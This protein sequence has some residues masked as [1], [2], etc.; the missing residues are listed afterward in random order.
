GLTQPDMVVCASFSYGVVTANNGCL[1][2]ELTI[3]GRATHG[4]MP[5]SGHDALR[6]A[7]RIL[8]EIY[9]QADTLDQIRSAVPGIES[10]TMIVG[11]IEGGTNTNV[12]PGRVV[13]KMD[14]RMIPEEDPAQVEAQ[15][16]AFIQAAVEGLPGIRVS[17]RRL[18]LAHPLRPLPGHE[19]MV[20][21]LQR[22]AQAI[23]GEP[24]T[25]GGTP[26]Y[27][28]ARLY[29]EH[30]IPVVMYGAGPRTLMES[31]AKQAD[32]NLAL[33]DLKAA[34]QVVAL[35]LADFLAC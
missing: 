14:R 13:L 16:R 17:V 32:E 1:Q 24:I 27:A 23:L 28:D 4:S 18:L 33:S 12:V 26:L 6:A 20:A 21:S 2:F 8:D 30:G 3:D 25:V 19:Q 31:R 5:K 34:T 29:G 15:V 35:M 10:P 9:R 22:H 11:R 7:S